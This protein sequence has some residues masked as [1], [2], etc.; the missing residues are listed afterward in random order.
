MFEWN[1]SYSVKL[2]NID[3][4]HQKLFRIA[5]ELHA[6]MVAGKAQANVANLLDRLVQYVQVHFAYEERIM[7]Q[8]GYPDF[9][10]HKALHAELTRQVLQFQADLESGK[11]TLSV[12]LLH[13]LKKWLLNH[14]KNEDSKYAPFVKAA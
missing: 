12:S 7:Q 9:A 14:I 8:V 4:Q 3:G 6:A 13:F 10:A 5:S 11:Q 1:D 2:P